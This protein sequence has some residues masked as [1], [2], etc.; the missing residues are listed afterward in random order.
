LVIYALMQKIIGDYTVVIPGI[1]ANFQDAVTPNFLADKN[2]MIWGIHYL[3]A[4]STYQNGNVFGANLLLIGF[5]VIANLR[6][7]LKGTIVPLSL[8]GVVVLLTASASIYLG[9][10]G[11]LL[12]MFFTAEKK[13]PMALIVML[14]VIVVSAVMFLILLNTDNIFSKI[15]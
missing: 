2:N 7:E 4:T 6:N 5:A 14:L 11:A 15:I 13:S 8:L 1:T 9:M 10:I 3:K 12:W